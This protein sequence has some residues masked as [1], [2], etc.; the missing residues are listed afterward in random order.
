MRM[1]KITNITQWISE[2]EAN[3]VK[4]AYLSY[5]KAHTLNCMTSRFNCG[6]GHQR[7]IF[8]HYHYCTDLEVAVLVCETREQY[9][10]NKKNGDIYGWKNQ[11]PK[12]YR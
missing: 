6:R 8:V 10:I 5:E 9:C 11:I 4:S 3:M 2:I 7:G 12:N 1:E